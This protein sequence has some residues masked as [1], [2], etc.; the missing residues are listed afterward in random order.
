M[1]ISSNL[2][3]HVREILQK[4]ANITYVH[5]CIFIFELVDKYAVTVA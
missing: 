3:L 1:H 5:T 4:H 2:F